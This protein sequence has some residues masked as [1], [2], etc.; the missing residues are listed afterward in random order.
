MTENLS[1]DN[2][3]MRSGGHKTVFCLLRRKLKTNIIL[4][5]EKLLRS[6]AVMTTDDAA[7]PPYILSLLAT[8]N[9]QPPRGPMRARGERRVL[10][11][12][13]VN[14]I[15]Q[16]ASLPYPPREELCQSAC[17]NRGRLRLQAGLKRRCV[18]CE[19]GACCA[20]WRTPAESARGLNRDPVDRFR[21]Q[22]FTGEKIQ[23]RH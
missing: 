19:D 2:L 22:V 17:T 8:G 18:G 16:E 21:T 4:E 3:I 13:A 9:M 6:R 15:F 5:V 1:F 14:G 23:V 20:E 7:S 12:V 11:L 10:C